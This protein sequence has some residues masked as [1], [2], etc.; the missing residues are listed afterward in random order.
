LKNKER[1]RDVNKLNGEGGE[2]QGLFVN[3]DMLRKA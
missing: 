3:R 1:E 2:D